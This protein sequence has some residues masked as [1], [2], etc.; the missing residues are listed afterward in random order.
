MSKAS[1][2]IVTP[3]PAQV[4]DGSTILPPADRSIDD[5]LRGTAALKLGT[6][7]DA[8]VRQNNVVF[9]TTGNGSDLPPVAVVQD[10]PAPAPGK[11]SADIYAKTKVQ[12]LEGFYQSAARIMDHGFSHPEKMAFTHAL[13]QQYAE[14]VKNRPELKGR[15]EDG[16]DMRVRTQLLRDDNFDAVMARL[17]TIDPK[18]YDKLVALLGKDRQTDGATDP[19]GYSGAPEDGRVRRTDPKPPVVRS[20]VRTDVRQDTVP[21][22]RVVGGDPPPVYIPPVRRASYTGADDN[23]GRGGMP[24]PGRDNIPI[25]LPVIGP[26]L[27]IVGRVVR[28]ITDR[29]SIYLHQTNSY[30]CGAFSLAMAFADMN[31]RRPSAQDAYQIENMPVAGTTIARAGQFPG[32]LS[33]MAGLAQ[34]TGLNARPYDYD[35][36]GVGM[37]TL[38][39]LN[40]ELDKGHGAL[41]R[42]INPTTG[43]NHWVYCSGRTQDGRYLIADP[44][45]RNMGPGGAHNQPIGGNQ[46]LR[47]MNRGGAGFVAVWSSPQLVAQRA[48]RGN[49]GMS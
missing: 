47:E 38:Q 24:A 8:E 15:A 16:S 10:G 1:D 3:E 49:R 25:K 39:D 4:A 18:V 26:L 27:D 29:D 37:H 30:G 14:D 22:Q 12:K 19:Y 9:R 40:A 13:K 17:K 45:R 7:P 41:V 23:G 43:N 44:A 11:P 42:I 35:R 21:P 6:V 2:R 34:R 36:R 33:D 28:N 20:D 31:G 32:G 5:Y 48:Q 46:L